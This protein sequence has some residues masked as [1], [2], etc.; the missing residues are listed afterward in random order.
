MKAWFSINDIYYLIGIVVML[1][2]GMTLRD[3]GNPKR[4][5]TALFWF[6]FGSTFLFGD[7]ITAVLG[8]DMAYRL[9]GLI[10]IALALLAGAGCLASGSYS[11]SSDQQRREAASRLGNKIFLPALLIPL[12]TVACTVLLKDVGIG[13]EALLDQK[14]L[15]LAALA[16]SCVCALLLGWKLTGGTP[17]QA[18]RESRRLV[19]SIGWAAI[20]PQMLAMLG[21]VFVA[22]KTGQ[23]VQEVVGLFVDP[24]NR[25]LLVAIY[26]IG[27]ALFTM[28]MGNAFAAFPVMTAGIALPFL[29]VGHHADAAPLVAIGMYSGYCGTLMTPM[30]ANFNIV[31][32]ALLELKD[33]YLV[34]KTQIP[35]ALALLGVNIL[36]MYFIVFR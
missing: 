25:F 20:L 5:T 27:M 3:R 29:I 14:H 24:D 32:A 10:V 12:L 30:A 36:L 28:I 35:T 4:Y 1:L 34:I 23:A 19:D 16:V 22:A 18:V 21:G 31:P 2:V 11:Q 8:K 17:L 26:C 33:R 13:G 9:V 7:L 15:T 6:L